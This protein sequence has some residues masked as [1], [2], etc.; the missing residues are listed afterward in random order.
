MGMNRHKTIDYVE[1]QAEDLQA[2][3]QFYSQVFGWTFEDYGPDY[4]SFKDGRI[5]G[6]FSRGPASGKGGPL[7]V[8]FVNDLEATEK[9]VREAG[10]V[11]TKETFSF[12]GGSRFHFDDPCG[13]ELA[14][15]TETAE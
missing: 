4:T 6:G 7:V 15:W 9:A 3:R 11:I 5:A 13:N 1:F 10:G 2:I 8:I 12:P 14:A